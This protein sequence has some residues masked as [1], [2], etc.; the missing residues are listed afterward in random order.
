MFLGTAP[1]SLKDRATKAAHVSASVR[2]NLAKTGAFDDL[3]P[4]HY[5]M[6]Q[7]I[8]RKEQAKDLTTLPSLTNLWITGPP[9]SGKS[10]HLNTTLRRPVNDN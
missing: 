3:P 8:R 5:H 4:E 10:I 1:L 7:C 6:Y 2:S 9:R